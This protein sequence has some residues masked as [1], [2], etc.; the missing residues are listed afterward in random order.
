MTVAP[1]PLR[2]AALL[3]FI[4]LLGGCTPPNALRN[5]DGDPWVKRNAEALDRMAAKLNEYGT[6]GMSA[7]LIMTP[8][9]SFDFEIQ[10]HGP[11][12]YFAEAKAEI[13]ARAAASNKMY[14]CSA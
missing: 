12:Q 1:R 6:V 10:S 9:K 5:F 11:E 4:T 8:D 14:R 7:P 2:L 3:G 13:Q